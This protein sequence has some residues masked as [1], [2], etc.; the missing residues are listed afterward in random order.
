MTDLR[1]LTSPLGPRLETPRL[2]LR[3]PVAE[4]FEGFCAFHA[5]ELTMKHLGGTISAPVVWR[6]MRSMVGQWALD[7]FSM[8]SVIEKETG[9]WIGRIGPLCPHGW[10]GEEVGWGLISKAWGKGYAKE[11]AIASMDYACD[12]LG[13]E[14]IIHTIAPE[15]LASAALAK[16][17]GSHNLGPTQ[18][19][20]PY[21]DMEIDKWGQSRDEWRVNRQKWL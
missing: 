12:H 8:F 4:D 17:L 10:P 15:N 13:W 1:S 5:D 19:P 9:A 2:I 16:A 3:P 7:G 14:M 21:G 11:A 6:N 20:A 18:L